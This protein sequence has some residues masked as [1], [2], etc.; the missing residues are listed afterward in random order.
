MALSLLNY[1]VL[2]M[3]E[4]MSPF[5]MADIVLIVCFHYVEK[6]MK[7]Q[8]ALRVAKDK[9][10]YNKKHENDKTS[11]AATKKAQLDEQKRL[12]QMMKKGGSRGKTNQTNPHINQ[13]D[14]SK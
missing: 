2:D 5:M 7:S 11:K 3:E 9:E 12:Q 13:P 14:K 8:R 4:A 1:F 10:A 6:N